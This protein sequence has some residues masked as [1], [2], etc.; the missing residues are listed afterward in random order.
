ML[1]IAAIISLRFDA[2]TGVAVIMLGAGIGV[3]GST[4]NPRWIR[5]YMPGPIADDALALPSGSS[6]QPGREH[7]SP[8]RFRFGC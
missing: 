1:V 6:D 2:L 3:I 7:R 5:A 8:R 4:V